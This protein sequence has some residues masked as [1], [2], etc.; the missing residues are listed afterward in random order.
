MIG[1]IIGMRIDEQGLG[2]PRF[3]HNAKPRLDL[4]E[5][6]AGS[7]AGLDVDASSWL[8]SFYLVTSR[9]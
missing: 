6:S 4:Q 9:T 5:R 2:A 8:A 3:A 1:E 7:A